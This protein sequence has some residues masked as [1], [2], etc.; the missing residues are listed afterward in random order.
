VAVAQVDGRAVAFL[1]EEQGLL[2]DGRRVAA[3]TG[4]TFET[5]NPSTGEVLA[6]VAEG[7]A[8]DIDSAVAAARRSFE[9]GVWRTKLTPRARVEVML[10]LCEL[11]EQN[12]EELAHL[13]SLDAG[14][15]LAHARG[16]DL[17]ISINYLR[18]A[19]TM[20]DKIVGETKPVSVPNTLSYTV[21]EPVGV[22]AAIIPWNYP[23]MM[24]V[25]KVGPALACGN[26][27]VLKPAEQTPLTALRLGELALEAGVPPGVFNVVPGIGEVA[28][29]ALARHPD[30]DKIAFTGSTAV[31]QDIVR[32]SAGNLKRVSL[33]LGGKSPHIVFADGDVATAVDH[34]A[35]GIFYNQGQDCTAGSRV[36][37]ERSAYDQVSEALAL[38][39]KALRVGDTMDAE[40]EQ[41][42][43]ITG[44]HRERV[45][46]YVDGAGNDG[47]AVLA[48][49]SVIDGPGFFYEPTVLGPTPNLARIAQE[50][51]FGP[52][53]VVIPF[54]SEEDVI[55]QSNQS[56]YG[57]AAGFWTRDVNRALR[58]A[59]RLRAG[60]VWINGWGYGDPATPFGGF[61]MSGWGRENGREVFDMYTEVKNVWM[62]FHD[63]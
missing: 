18:Y 33:E 61:K 17:P 29:A 56:K 60:R 12:S 14:K 24:A 50:E 54:D 5:V 52:V 42:P 45:K 40:T 3:S 53:V 30:V 2:I 43:L 62:H 39:A 9:A 44:E 11:L 51:V 63:D 26:S 10:R 58:V 47:I 38:K 15:P 6:T 35:A 31:G 37:V 23:L 19:A 1:A 41:G 46:G 27:L 25:W 13:E 48:G 57:L 7:D 49:G 59:S 22:C 16:D 28:G 20:P 21:R 36:F 32:A 55:L 8:T 4:R 34:A